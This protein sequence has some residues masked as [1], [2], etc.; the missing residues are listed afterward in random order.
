MKKQNRWTLLGFCATLFVG[1]QSYAHVEPGVHAGTTAD[2]KAC[3]FTAGVTTFENDMRHPLNERIE[4]KVGD[5]TFKVGH[6]AVID[7]PTKTAS[8]NHD[9]FHG[10]LPTATGAKALV[11]TMVHSQQFEG[12][13]EFVLIENAW[14]TKE[15]TALTCSGLKHVPAK[16]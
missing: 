7:V 14:R 10:V 6:P 5:N 3:S 9:F 16:K 1:A 2:G 8:F 11:I 15:K 13:S 12:P 4:I